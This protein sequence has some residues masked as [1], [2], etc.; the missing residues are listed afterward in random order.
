MAKKSDKRNGAKDF[1]LLEYDYMTRLH[2]DAKEVGEKRLNFLIAFSAAIGTV[3]LAAENLISTQSFRLVSISV[4]TLAIV[5]GV[6]T[7]GKMINRRIAIVIYRRR[8]SRIRGWFLDNYPSIGS[9]LPYKVDIKLPMNWGGRFVLGTTASSVA[10]INILLLAI[11]VILA[12]YL[13]SGSSQIVLAVIAAILSGIMKWIF[14][15][16]WKNVKLN[17]AERKDDEYLRK[18]ED[19]KPVHN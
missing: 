10:A 1:M 13:Y 8:L 3:L 19:P 4:L 16:I 2:N 6:I 15:I 11:L 7:F 18:L 14:L 5:I 9:G 12:F 17:N